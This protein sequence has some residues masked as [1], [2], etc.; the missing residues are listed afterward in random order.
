M[1]QALK[2]QRDIIALETFNINTPTQTLKNFFPAMVKNLGKIVDKLKPNQ[3]N[4]KLNVNKKEFL[5][6]VE[7]TNFLDIDEFKIQAPDGYSAGKNFK[8]YT[9]LLLKI[10]EK[11]AKIDSDLITPYSNYLAKLISTPEH[12][13]DTSNY[14]LLL[15]NYGKDRDPALAELKS[16]FEGSSKASKLGDVIK[17]N[18]DW[19]TIIENLEASNKLVG[20]V[21]LEK[22]NKKVDE[23]K[24]YLDIIAERIRADKLE[25]VSKEVTKSLSEGVYQIAKELEYFSVIY[26]HLMAMNTSVELIAKDVYKV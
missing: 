19:S 8:D 5:A 18:S 22:L 6:A 15:D 16:Y 14:F 9:A 12:K 7:K 17:R 25:N 1:T 4:L 20:S 11:L 10:S 2:I 3:S 26:Y 13:F 24:S 23:I 21:N